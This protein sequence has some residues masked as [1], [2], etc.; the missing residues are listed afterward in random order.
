M[1]IDADRIRGKVG[2]PPEGRFDDPPSNVRHLR[3]R[4]ENDTRQRMRPALTARLKELEARLQKGPGLAGAECGLT[5]LD[6]ALD[7]WQ[8]GCLYV[9]G[10]RTGMGKSIVGANI[11]TGLA[12]HG[13]G[14]AA[15]RLRRAA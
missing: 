15:G 2:A 9:I 1:R 8:R 3:P 14:W 10:G 12:A 4:Q 13:L 5:L 11:A 6:D 7:G